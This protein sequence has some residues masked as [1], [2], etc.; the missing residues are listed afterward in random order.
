MENLFQFSRLAQEIEL[1]FVISLLS[2]IPIIV[3]A[4]TTFTRNIIVLSFLRHALGLPQSPPNLVLIILALFI[5]MFTM[6][7]VFDASY[8]GGLKP[9]MNDELEPSVAAQEMWKPFKRFMILQTNEND[10]KFMYNIAEEV[11]PEL[12]S[13]VKWNLLVP[14]FLLS[15]LSLAFKIGFIIF[16]PF[17][18]IDLVMAA[19]LTSLG[20]IMVPPITISLPLKVMLFVTIDGWRL[21]TEVLLKSVVS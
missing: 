2:F 9:Y 3:V 16:L 8:H 21:I 5:T 7:P 14:A 11:P 12:A 19:I 4:F 10:I 15:E 18:L 20:M 1:F 6:R 17:L 13:D